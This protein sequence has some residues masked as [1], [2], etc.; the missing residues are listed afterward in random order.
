MQS[1]KQ[2]IRR[3][4]LEEFK[5]HLTSKQLAAVSTLNSFRWG[6]VSIASDLKRMGIG[7]NL[8][9]ALMHA[10]G[11]SNVSIVERM[12]NAYDHP[13]EIATAERIVLGL[14]H[15][16]IADS[17]IRGYRNPAFVFK[18][19]HFSSPGLA[20]NVPVHIQIAEAGHNVLHLG[21]NDIA[22]Q[23]YDR[24]FG[25]I[26]NAQA[27]DHLNYPIN[28]IARALESVGGYEPEGRAQALRQIRALKKK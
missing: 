16:G 15:N 28:T 19:I 23:I 20:D 13:E 4:A 18:A 6:S 17:L 25:P 14:D 1:P 8:R 27:L 10:A 26:L 24:H 11:H 9:V 5:Q 12:S 22:R 21:P 2:K 3:P 7:A